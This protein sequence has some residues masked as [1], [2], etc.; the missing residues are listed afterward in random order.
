MGNLLMAIFSG[1]AYA[2]LAVVY[3]Q[4]ERAHCRPA[5]FLLAFMT[6][7][8]V[9][10]LARA[11][12]E[13][14]TWGDP[15]FWFL[16]VGGGLLTYV[17]I[18]LIT[19]AN[20]IGPASVTWTIANLSLIAPILLAPLLFHEGLLLT[21]GVMML[22]FI[23]MLVL[24]TYGM[25]AGEILASHRGRFFLMAGGVFLADSIC[26]V[27]NKVKYLWFAD[28]NTAGMPALS[29]LSAGLCAFA[30]YR[31]R[32][33]WCPLRASEWKYGM[34]A[35]IFCSIGVFCLLSAMRLPVVLSLPLIKGL[36]LV[37]GALLVAWRFRESVTIVK[38]SAMGCGL[39]VILFATLRHPLTTLV[40]TLFR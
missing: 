17:S 6:T 20:A 7:G 40:S 16:G 8:G 14:T 19:R 15:R 5:G 10:M 22:L 34:T 18:N 26:Q 31:I 4:V 25:R 36:S 32:E 30:I 37:I 3:K 23:A 29:F 11:M 39:L 33:G 9:I 35:G 28:A 38:I 21:D 27:L 12:T 2:L 13:H 1:I 24:F